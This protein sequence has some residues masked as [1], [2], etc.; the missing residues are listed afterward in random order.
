MAGEVTRMS[1]LNRKH[2]L[3]L[4][5]VVVASHASL[6]LHVNSHVAAEQQTCHLCTHFSGLDYA[7]PPAAPDAFERTFVAPEPVQAAVFLPAADT[8][9]WRQRAPPLPA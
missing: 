3:L 2:C 9:H 7:P 6:T 1:S 8:P 5:L 4:L